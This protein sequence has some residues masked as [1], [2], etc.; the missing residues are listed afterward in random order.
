MQGYT[1]TA[2]TV[3]YYAPE[4]FVCLCQSGA[5]RLLVS[6]LRITHDIVRV[7]NGTISHCHGELTVQKM[8]CM[9][10]YVKV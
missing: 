2:Y 8:S 4:K 10:M 1:K 6:T 5:D 9:D 3:C 7:N